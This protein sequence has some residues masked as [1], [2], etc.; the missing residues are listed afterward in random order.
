MTDFVSPVGRLIYGSV[1]KGNDKGYQNRP[2]DVDPST[3]LP[4]LKWAFGL[5]VEK[6]NPELPAFMA[7]L[8]GSMREAWPTFQG[9]MSDPS[10]FK[11][12]IV[13]GDTPALAS[14]AGYAGCIIFKIESKFLPTVF[15]PDGQRVITN[16]DEVKRGFFIQ[17]AGS[18]T[19]NGDPT[20]SG[21]K[22]WG[23]KVLFKFAGEEIKG[24]GGDPS[25]F[26]NTGGYRPAGA[27]D[28]STPASAPATQVFAPQAQPVTAPNPHQAPASHVGT[29]AQPSAGATTSPSDNPAP[30]QDWNFLN[31]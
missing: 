3:G 29:Q 17:V 12:K 14:K 8:Q 23:S 26:E 24:T 13:D 15:S 22:M 7:L 5:A 25:C 30:A 31:Q 1:F 2:N 21:M 28:A 4:Q 10:V 18:Y 11:A 19:T 16:P 6:A 27:I 20:R 9:N